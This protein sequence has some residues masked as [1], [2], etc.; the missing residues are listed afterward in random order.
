MKLIFLILSVAAFFNVGI[1]SIAQAQG[2][3]LWPKRPPE[4]EQARSFVRAGKGEEAVAVLHPFVTQSGVVGRE[5][6]KIT[7]AVQVPIYLS[8]RNPHAT[9]YV[10]KSG[11]TLGR[12]SSATN[13]PSELILLLNGIVNPSALRAGQK[14]VVFQMNLRAEVN[15]HTNEVTVWDDA[16]LVACYDIEEH[17][18][19]SA[20]ENVAVSVEAREGILDGSSLAKNSTEFL[21]SQRVLK[22]SDGISILSAPKAQASSVCLSAQDVNEL[23]L[24]LSI[25]SRVDIIHTDS[26]Q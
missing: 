2:Y 10:V 6:R 3:S 12:I 19:P 13:C 8:R 7:A 25:G 17:S 5:A 23:A 11:D 20:K 26:S 16:T 18:I 1:V 14:L 24:L 15:L 9:I 22:L 21:A 4:I